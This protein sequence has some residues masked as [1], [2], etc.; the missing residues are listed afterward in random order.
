MNCQPALYSKNPDQDWVLCGIAPNGAN[1][2]IAPGY[3]PPAYQGVTALA[4]L[5]ANAPQGF[6]P[7]FVSTWTE[8]VASEFGRVSIQ[9]VTP[10]Q[11]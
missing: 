9:V 11:Y 6:T 8:V 7:R 5:K 1:M 2:V 4:W 3:N 10:G